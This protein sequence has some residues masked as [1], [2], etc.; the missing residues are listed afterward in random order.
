MRPTPMAPT[1]MRLLGAICPK[2]DEGRIVGKPATAATPTDVF[3]KLRRETLPIVFIPSPLNTRVR[4]ALLCPDD[5]LRREQALGLILRHV[6][7]VHNIGDERRV[8]EE[9]RS[10]WAP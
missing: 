4:C 8:G 5:Q 10:R 7:P 1:L 3:R 2:T 6:R 9:R